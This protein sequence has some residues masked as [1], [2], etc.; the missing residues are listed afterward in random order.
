MGM[1]NTLDTVLH[2]IVDFFG[3]NRAATTTEYLD[4]RRTQFL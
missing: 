2:Q 1:V 4:M 3:S